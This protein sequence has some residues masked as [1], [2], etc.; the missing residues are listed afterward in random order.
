MTNFHGDEAKKFKKGHFPAPPILNILPWNF[1]GLVLGLVGLI[2]AKGIDVAQSAILDFFFA[3]SPWKSVTN[4]VI[5]WMGINFDVSLVSS[6]FLAMRNIVLYSVG[7][8]VVLLHTLMRIS[9]HFYFDIKFG[10]RLYSKENR[11][12]SLLLFWI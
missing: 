11:P 7:Y 12:G 1:H 4:Y 5:E 10:V 8:Y 9:S 3:W 2:D 6:K